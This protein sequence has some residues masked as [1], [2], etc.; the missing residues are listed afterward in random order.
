ME[1]KVR[2]FIKQI[3]FESAVDEKQI[4]RVKRWLD[5]YQLRVPEYSYLIYNGKTKTKKYLKSLSILTQACGDLS[6]FFFNEK[7]DITIDKKK[8]DKILTKDKTKEKAKKGC[9]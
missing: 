7:L 2:E 4:N 6:D 5:W 1:S 3:G 8:V 9:C